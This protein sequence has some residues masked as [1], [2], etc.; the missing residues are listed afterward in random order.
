[1]ILP[2][3]PRTRKLLQQFNL[4]HHL[5]SLTVVDP[6][7]FLDMVALEQAAKVIL[8]D[9]GGVQ[10]EAFFYRVPCIT[11]RDETEWVET[12][13]LGWNQL[14]GACRENILEAYTT[15]AKKTPKE[16]ASPYGDGHA[17]EHIINHLVA[18]SG[19]LSKHV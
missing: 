15:F 7:P 11:M 8:T 16:S 18:N 13:D 10:K 6:L 19:S 3:H 4:E 1:V 5:S 9:S 14:V 2:L 17:S 12:V